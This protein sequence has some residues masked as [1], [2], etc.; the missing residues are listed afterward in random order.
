M[1]GN[2]EPSLKEPRVHPTRNGRFTALLEAIPEAAMLLGNDR[3]IVASNQHFRSVFADNLEVEGRSCYQVSHCR[4]QPC[5]S[6]SELCPLQRC[7]ETGEPA[8]TVHIHR[9]PGGDV[10]TS[11]LMRPLLN[12][13]G[14]IDNFLEI[15][16]PL[17]I[18]SATASRDQLVGRSP[19]FNR[20]LEELELVGPTEKAVSIF[21]EAG[22]GKELVAR[23][24]HEISPRAHR[25]F[26]PVDCAA[27][28]EWQ[29]ERELFGHTRGAFPGAA[30]A[31]TGFVGAA[32]G[33]TLF[34]K[35]VEALSSAAQVK[36]LRLLETG[37]FTPE[38]ATQPQRSEFRL[39]CSSTKSLEDLAATGR[40]RDDLR[41]QIGGFPIAVP[42]L[43]DRAGDIPLLVESLLGRLERLQPS[44][45][46]DP[47]TLEVLQAY[48]FP[49]NVRELIHVLEHACLMADGQVLLPEHLPSDCLAGRRVA[50]SKLQF[51][52]DV[53]PLSDAEELYIAWAS[54]QATGS[55][56]QLARQLGISERT[57]Y[58]KLR[59]VRAGSP[60]EVTDTDSNP[61]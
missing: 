5:E 16:K 34:L 41:H 47:R 51:E 6:R 17:K 30:E 54:E 36:L 56:R 25:A 46:V 49:G 43:H 44:P 15:L 35:E 13:K 11:V 59:K 53:V 58:R 14:E 27:L 31:R 50:K 23:A 1:A 10:H 29:F 52:G 22:T 12:E 48:D 19:K 24:V 39:I 26:V 45:E 32:D 4:D 18:A 57:L 61:R 20:M 2:E 33:G 28:H 8:R 40:F 38:G 9:T 3:T 21:G 37:F 42:T 7:L 55:Q 60:P